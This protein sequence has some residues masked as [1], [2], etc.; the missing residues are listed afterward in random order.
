MFSK[1]SLIS[2]LT[3]A[4]LA[5]NT[6]AGPILK[7]A[8]AGASG[9]IP[10]K[11][12]VV[13]KK[14]ITDSQARAHTSRIASFHSNVARDLTGPR[15]HGVQNQFKFSSTGFR[16]YSGGFD[17][18]TLQQIL[19]SPEVDYVEQDG[20][21]TASAIQEDA[22]WGLA[23]ISHKDYAPSTDAAPKYNYAY[24]EN[25]AGAGVTVYVID[26]GV[27]TTHS[28]F[29]TSSDGSRGSRAEWGYNAVDKSF[30]D[31]NGHGTHCAGTIAGK[32]YGVSKEAKIKAV[33]VLNAGGSGTY[34]GVIG[35]MNWVAEDAGPDHNNTAN[36]AVASM[37]LGGGKSDA[38]NQ[39]G[40]AMV[41]AGVVLVVAGGNE[42]QDVKNVSP[43][44][45][46]EAITVGAI[47]KN[48]AKA[49]FSN[50]GT[51]LD[52][53]AAGVDVMSSWGTGDTDTKTIS[54]TSMACPH[55]AGL[56]AYIISQGK[57]TSPAEVAEVI[58]QT[59]V[60]D[61]VTGDIK[62]SPN[63]IAYNNYS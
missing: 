23:R 11:Y 38:I 36:K 30:S 42:N 53:W 21:V 8:N 57:T 18:A 39:A 32:T 44:S 3:V 24:D 7:I 58:S 19:R 35:G 59:A 26:T 12:I 37:S 22:T 31:G 47:D 2:L 6:L 49:S 52:I 62:G 16:G 4:G 46:P 14:D 61:Q 25:A 5:T 33:K 45:T 43:A 50:W 56:A 41:K 13:L 27:R 15:S 40:A 51:S 10:D 60:S 9:L 1:I 48:N 54:G 17:F 55:V 63:K 29:Q 20:I 34:A 28:E